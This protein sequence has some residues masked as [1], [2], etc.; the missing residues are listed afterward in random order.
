MNNNHNN[1]EMYSE[2]I[3]INSTNYVA[4]SGN[5][6]EFKFKNGEVILGQGSKIALLRT[7]IYNCVYNI[8]S[9]LGNNK[10]SIKWIDG[11]VYDSTIKDGYYSINDLN[12]FIANFLYSNHLYTTESDTATD[13]TA[14]IFLSADSIAYGSTLVIDPVPTASSASSSGIIK[15]PEATWSYPTTT[16]K[17]PEI[18]FNSGLQKLLGFTQQS[19][20]GAQSNSSQSIFYS[21]STPIVSTIDSYILVCNMIYNRLSTSYGN[22]LHS[23]P[24]GGSQFGEQVDDSASY[25]INYINVVPNRYASLIIEVLDQNFN[26]VKL[27]DTE[28][29]IM[30]SIQY[31][32]Q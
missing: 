26:P 21:A 27:L 3:I 31:P 18:T 24:L 1:N 25:G 23:I 7:T 32:V 12:Y 8:S 22:V 10:F 19:T 15:P 2:T 14:Y 29:N 6:F 4:N 16:A 20:Y 28:V 17:Q 30:L 11:S 9:A 5:R 13:F